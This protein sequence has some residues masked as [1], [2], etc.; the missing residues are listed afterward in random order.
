MDEEGVEY[1]LVP[2]G[3][4]R[5]NAAERAIRSFKNHFLAG[6]ALCNPK[7]PIAEWDHLLDQAVLTLNLLQASRV[8]PKL[9]KNAGFSIIRKNTKIVQVSPSLTKE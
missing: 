2:P 4:H 7:F 1:Q 6:M 5:R 8:N 3:Q 9:I